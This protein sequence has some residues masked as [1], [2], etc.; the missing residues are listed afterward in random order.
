MILKKPFLMIKDAM[1]NHPGVFFV[2]F[3]ILTAWFI[4]STYQELKEIYFSY[5]VHKY[6]LQ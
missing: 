3:A 2:L 4:Q 6:N 5:I 1:V